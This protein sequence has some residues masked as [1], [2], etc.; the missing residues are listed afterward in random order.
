MNSSFPSAA[1]GINKYF[2]GHVPTLDLLNLPENEGSE[3]MR[4]FDLLFVG[5]I[6]LHVGGELFVLRKRLVTS[7][8]SSAR[9][10]GFQKGTQGTAGSWSMTGIQTLCCATRFSS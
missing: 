4:D 6:E 9:L 10:W 3:S 5:V 7:E 8:I 2:W 1:C